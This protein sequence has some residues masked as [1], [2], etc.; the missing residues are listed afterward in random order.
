M[1]TSDEHDDQVDVWV[2]EAIA[3]CLDLVARQRVR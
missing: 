1:T 2:D 3:G